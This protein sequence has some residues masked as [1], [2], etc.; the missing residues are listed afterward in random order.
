MG[1]VRVCETAGC[2]VDH[3]INPDTY[4]LCGPQR[5]RWLPTE[6]LAVKTKYMLEI[7]LIEKA[8]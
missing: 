4:L 5:L 8:P 7:H 2:E 6:P 1:I 3:D